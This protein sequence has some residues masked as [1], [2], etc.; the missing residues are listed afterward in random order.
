MSTPTDTD[1]VAL[2]Q[3]TLNVLILRTLIF[4]FG[5]EPERG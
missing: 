3:G 5:P 4:G 2:L 1:R